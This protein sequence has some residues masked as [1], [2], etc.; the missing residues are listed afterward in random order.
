MEAELYSHKREYNVN[1]DQCAIC[2]TRCK[3]TR[4]I[5]QHI[6][7]YILGHRNVKLNPFRHEQGAYPKRII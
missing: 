7:T 4:N 5:H 6:K 2:I 1:T 3:T